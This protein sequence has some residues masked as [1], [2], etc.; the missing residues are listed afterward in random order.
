MEDVVER[1][2]LLGATFVGQQQTLVSNASNGAGENRGNTDPHDVVMK[3]TLLRGEVEGG[4][5]NTNEDGEDN[6]D[7]NFADFIQR[8]DLEDSNQKEK[9]HDDD[10]HN[11]G[12]SNLANINNGRWTDEEHERFCQALKMYGKDWNQIQDYIGTRT[13]AQIRSH[14]QKY[15]S[16]L[17]K[18]GKLEVLEMFD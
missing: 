18:E 10:D 14:A 6:N 13:S 2:T 7:L 17:F 5:E 4:G 16:K 1:K 3:A 12:S 9:I 11:G 15:F 8:A